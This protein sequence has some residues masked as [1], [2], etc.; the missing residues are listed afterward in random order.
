MEVVVGEE[1][2]IGVIVE[3]VSKL[4]SVVALRVCKGCC[5]MLRD[6]VEGL[7]GDGTGD[8]FERDEGEEGEDG[9]EMEDELWFDGE[10]QSPSCLDTLRLT[11]ALLF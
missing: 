4:D 6:T 3:A 5:V 2:V 1:W 11:L 7:D 10:E 8:S 9:G